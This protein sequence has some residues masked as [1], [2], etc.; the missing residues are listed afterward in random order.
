MGAMGFLA[1]LNTE[2]SWENTE[3]SRYP[4]TES[5]TRLGMT[6]FPNR[7]EKKSLISTPKLPTT[8]LILVVLVCY[9]WAPP[10]YVNTLRSISSICLY[11]YIYLTSKANSDMPL[12]IS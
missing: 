7:T 10:V 6:F 9:V 8:A 12:N 5:C 1:I 3:V 2:A 4:Q 11:V